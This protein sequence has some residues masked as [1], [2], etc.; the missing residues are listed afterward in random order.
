MGAREELEEE[1][2]ELTEKAKVS[3]EEEKCRDQ[4]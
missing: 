4:C 1:E 3:A 2:R